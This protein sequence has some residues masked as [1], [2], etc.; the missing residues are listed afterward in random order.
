MEPQ[1]EDGTCALET[2]QHLLDLLLCQWSKDYHTAAQQ[3]S[4][5]PEVEET[6]PEGMAGGS[7]APVAVSYQ[8]PEH[9]LPAPSACTHSAAAPPVVFLCL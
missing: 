6:G 9:K 1:V 7:A 3:V 4:V 2:G 8:H 5:A